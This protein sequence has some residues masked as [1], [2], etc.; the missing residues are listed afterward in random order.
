MALH[1]E[2]VIEAALDLLDEVGLD[3]LTTRALTTRLGV[4]PGALYWHVKSK[5]EL[6]SA[7][8]D[9]IMREAYGTPG[10]A[11]DDAPGDWVEQTTAFA[12]RTRRAM[13][14]RRD[15]ARVVAGHLPLTAAALDASEAGLALLRA[16][17]LPL[18]QAAYFGHT[19]AS[20][21]TGFALQEQAA[22][23]PAPDLPAI[24]PERYPHMAAWAAEKPA[25]KDAA[26]TAGLA[27][28]IGGLRAELAADA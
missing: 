11:T 4:A 18:A 2:D 12:H 17:G 3:K 19:V 1:R 20:Y 15:G 8:A 25:E 13:L 27:L 28:I 9:R 14:A 21:V 5:A 24:E 16:T 23:T 22:P 7:I 6:L 26:F 10:N